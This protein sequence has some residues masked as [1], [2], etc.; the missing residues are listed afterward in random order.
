MICLGIYHNGL[1]VY[2]L[3]DMSYLMQNTGNDDCLLSVL[4]INLDHK[5]VEHQPQVKTNR[6][7]IVVILAR[8]SRPKAMV[9]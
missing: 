5:N 4:I 6:V 3:R 2:V 7:E 1:F 8:E 9:S